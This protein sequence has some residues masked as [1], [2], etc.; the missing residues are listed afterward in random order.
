MNEQQR[1]EKDYHHQKSSSSDCGLLL[2]LFLECLSVGSISDVELVSEYSRMICV[3]PLLAGGG[4]NE[5]ESSL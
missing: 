1:K 2:L 3:G 5:L 4:V